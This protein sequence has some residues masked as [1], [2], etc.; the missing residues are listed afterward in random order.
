MTEFKDHLEST[1]KEG[2]NWNVIDKIEIDHIKPLGSK[3]ISVD[4]KIA[5][6]NYKNTQALWPSENKRK[7]NSDS[8]S[9]IDSLTEQLNI[10]VTL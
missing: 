5:R 7:G 3:E 9:D 4:E 1:F 6:L 2:M 10:G 8:D